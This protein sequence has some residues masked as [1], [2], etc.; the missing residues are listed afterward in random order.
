MPMTTTTNTCTESTARICHMRI[1]SYLL[2]LF[3]HCAQHST[4][5]AVTILDH[6]QRYPKEAAGR[7]VMMVWWWR[8]EVI[9]RSLEKTTTTAAQYENLYAQGVPPAVAAAGRQ[10]CGAVGSRR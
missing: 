5:G 7:G 2:L 9:D 6:T 10:G 3:A 8:G 4:A 1:V